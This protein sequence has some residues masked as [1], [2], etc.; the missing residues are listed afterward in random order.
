MDK[1]AQSDHPIHPLIQ[2]RWSPRAF[3]DKTVDP[4]ILCSLLEAARWAAS[5]FNEQPWAFIIATWDDPTE[6]ARLL[7]CLVPGNQLWAKQAPVLMLSVAKMS[8]D[9]N[10]KPN[11]HAYHDVGLAV[12]TMILQAMSMD[13]Y[14]HQMGG[15]DAD[16]ARDTYGIPE[17]YEPVAAI[18]IGYAGDPQTLPDDFRGSEVA[19]RER[20]SIDSFV[21][22]GRWGDTSAIVQSESE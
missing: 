22:T 21:F 18:A 4:D 5:S 13:L 7:S 20:K 3:S 6:Y 16:K 8:F 1:P 11:R 15:F 14:A 17:G 12:S 2:K 9:R 19:P 10:G